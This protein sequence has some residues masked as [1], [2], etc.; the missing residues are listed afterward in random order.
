MKPVDFDGHAADYNANLKK[1]L[2][3]FDADDKYFAEYKIRIV[4]EKLLYPPERILE[5]GCGIGRNLKALKIYFPKARISGCDISRESLRYAKEYPFATLYLLGRDTIREKFDLVFIS[6]VFHHVE[7]VLR[8][9]IVSE[10][11]RL[12]EES[13]QVFVFEHNP[14]NPVTR[15]LVDKCPFDTGAVLLSC[16]ELGRLFT[17]AKFRK[18]EHQYTLFFPTRFKAWR[19]MEKYLGWLPLGGQYF[20]RFVK[21]EV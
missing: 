15:R 2:S 5:Y 7:P 19:Q 17:S 13:G 20:A 12:L 4:K 10:I 14:F 9:G 16:K 1:Q 6:C 3:F 8:K 11:Y 21:N 18:I